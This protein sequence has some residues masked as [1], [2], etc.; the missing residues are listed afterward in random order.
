MLFSYL[1]PFV[2]AVIIAALV[3]KPAKLLS[4]KIPLKSGTIASIL[5][6]LFFLLF[7]GLTVF[8]IY[9]LSLLLGSFLKELP[10]FL[11][12]ITDYISKIENKIAS[13]FKEISPEFS[14][15]INEI[16]DGMLDTVTRRATDAFSSFAAIIAKKTP[17]FLF[18]SIISLAASCFIAKDFDAL[19]NFISLL[20][21]KETYSKFLKIKEIFSTNVIKILK[22]YFWL[23]VLTFIE[24]TVGLIILGIEFAPLLALL[25]AVVDLL[26]VLGTG[27]VL[28][29]WAVAELIF[30][31]TFIGVSIL[32]IYALVTII[33]NFAEPKI[34]GKQIGIHP[35]FTLFSMFIGLKFFGVAGIF[36]LPITLIVVIKYYKDELDE[37]RSLKT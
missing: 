10:E 7:S 35:L 11:N 2:I 28:I 8:V 26:P 14:K 33:R 15:T 29:P 36:I 4:K 25:I 12:N 3:Q 20:C 37:E 5:A 32:V 9:R 24:L 1:L 22:G 21:G 23:F 17:S 6:L 19:N 16:V 34:I 30:G 18:S 31:K 13:G 27:A